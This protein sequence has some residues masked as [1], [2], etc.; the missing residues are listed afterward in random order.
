M[1]TVAIEVVLFLSSYAPFF[2]ITAFLETW[3]TGL[4]TIMAWVLSAGS[5]LGLVI[6]FRVA[7]TLHVSNLTVATGRPRDDDTIGYVVTYLLPFIT[8]LEPSPR[9]RIALAAML[10]L[11]ATL[12]V[13]AHLFYINPCLAVIG[14]RLFEIQVESGG[15][16]LLLTRRRLIRPGLAISVVTVSDYVLL[17]AA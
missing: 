9:L 10:V 16:F 8:F 6:F 3:G 5:I 12:Y 4:P 17:E 15:I 13:R 2:A 7:R 11:L 14:Y 1:P